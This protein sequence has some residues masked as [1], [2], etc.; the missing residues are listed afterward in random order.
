MKKL[1]EIT[2]AVEIVLTV[3]GKAAEA[4][5]TEKQNVDEPMK[6]TW[7]EVKQI[8]KD[9]RDEDILDKDLIELVHKGF[10][11]VTT[12]CEESDETV[13]LFTASDID[14]I[15]VF[16]EVRRILSGV[17]EWEEIISPA[18]YF[19]LIECCI[20]YYPRHSK[21]YEDV[22]D[23]ICSQVFSED[24]SSEQEED[25]TMAM[26]LTRAMTCYAFIDMF[27]H[28]WFNI[29]DYN[30]CSRELAMYLRHE[31]NDVRLLIEKKLIYAKKK[32]QNAKTWALWKLPEEKHR[33]AMLLRDAMEES[34]EIRIWCEFVYTFD[35]ASRYLGRALLQKLP[36]LGKDI[37]R[38]FTEIELDDVYNAADY[39]VLCSFN[40]TA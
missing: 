40:H 31:S 32:Y 17:L 7:D 25:E 6:F 10:I 22:V 27:W 14:K 36:A 8:I 35:D 1:N 2:E 3:E 5:I 38:D 13:P 4:E 30:A 16:L 9:T 23:F 34:E 26:F 19:G 29:E 37:G 39:Q 12:T 11:R 28:G 33:K 24:N 20:N 18:S 21:E 15:R